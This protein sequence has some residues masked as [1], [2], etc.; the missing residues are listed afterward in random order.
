[1]K[2][3]LYYRISQQT[4]RPQVTSS[5]NPHCLSPFPIRPANN[6]PVPINRKKARL[7]Y[8]SSSSIIANDSIH[9]YNSDSSKC[10][11]TISRTSIS[12]ISICRCSL[13]SL[14]LDNGTN[15]ANSQHAVEDLT[16]LIRL[17]QDSS[18]PVEKDN[19]FAQGCQDMPLLDQQ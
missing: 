12:Q 5:S 3:E 13:Q 19:R 8:D 2:S 9:S 10:D 14:S 11:S 16:D 17:R 6:S 4:T 15:N 18:N 7:L 1:M